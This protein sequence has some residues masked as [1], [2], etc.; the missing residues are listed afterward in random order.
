MWGS[1]L[2][3]ATPIPPQRQM[4]VQLSSANVATHHSKNPQLC[5]AL[6]VV[7]VPALTFLIPMIYL[8]ATLRLPYFC[9]VG[10]R[11]APLLDWIR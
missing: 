3:P 11:R 10:V 8:C 7:V 6:L 9:G 1:G 4:H 2:S 5:R